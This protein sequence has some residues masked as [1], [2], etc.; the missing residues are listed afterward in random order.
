MREFRRLCRGREVQV[1]VVVVVVVVGDREGGRQ[2]PG[3]RG[4]EAG[5]AR[6]RRWP[7]R[8]FCWAGRRI[9]ARVA[10]TARF[11]LSRRWAVVRSL[12]CWGGC[13]AGCCRRRV[14][15]SLMSGC[16][17]FFFYGSVS[18]FEGRAPIKLS[19][20]HG[21][22]RLG[23]GRQ[24]TPGHVGGV[25]IGQWGGPGERRNKMA[26]D[27]GAGERGAGTWE[28]RRALT[29]CHSGPSRG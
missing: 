12:A 1:L 13:W 5:D 16:H 10:R 3:T 2:S 14:C 23:P 24:W 20:M 8:D 9:R 11:G 22:G 18:G 7:S 29:K 4:R 6:G 17:L 27:Q 26:D 25:V 15:R 19:M 21:N 28:V